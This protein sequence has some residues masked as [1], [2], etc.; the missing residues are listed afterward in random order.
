MTPADLAVL[1]GLPDLGA[2]LAAVEDALDRA[3]VVGRDEIETPARRVVL[4]GG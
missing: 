4:G 2:G 3:I 1:L